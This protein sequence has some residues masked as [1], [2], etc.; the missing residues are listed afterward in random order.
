MG[1][2]VSLLYRTT[3]IEVRGHTPFIERAYEV[4]VD[5]AASFCLYKK[6][7][8]VPYINLIDISQLQP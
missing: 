4:E 6:R 1:V 7:F 5:R 8:L 2:P 3:V